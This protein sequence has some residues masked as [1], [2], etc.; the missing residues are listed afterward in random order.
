MIIYNFF[1]FSAILF[2]LKYINNKYRIFNI[3]LFCPLI[4]FCGDIMEN[5]FIRYMINSFPDVSEQICKLSNIFTLIK[6]IFVY[7]SL[8]F[9]CLSLII[10]FANKVIIK[11][12]K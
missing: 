9:V 7:I 5:I 3:I 12:S 4:T 11:N 10:L 1:Y 2:V 8:I 6:F